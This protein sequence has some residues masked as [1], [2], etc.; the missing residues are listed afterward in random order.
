MSHGTFWTA[1][2]NFY[3]VQKKDIR[4]KDERKMQTLTEGHKLIFLFIIFFTLFF[5]SFVI[6]VGRPGFPRLMGEIPRRC[7]N[8]LFHNF[9]AESC[10]KMKEF[11]V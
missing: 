10:M 7:A 3:E 5:F 8:L 11:R 9:F 4:E 2:Y 6:P 1:T